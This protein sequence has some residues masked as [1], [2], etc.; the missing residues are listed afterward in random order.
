MS[1]LPDFSRLCL[2]VPT[3]VKSA[4]PEVMQRERVRPQIAKRRHF[5]PLPES[6]TKL[7]EL[8]GEVVSTFDREKEG[9]NLFSLKQL[10]PVMEELG[11][12]L[13]EYGEILDKLVRAL[14][15][16][17]GGGTGLRQFEKRTRRNQALFLLRMLFRH[18]ILCPPNVCDPGEGEAFRERLRAELHKQVSVWAAWTGDPQSEYEFQYRQITQGQPPLP[19]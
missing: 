6:P 8:K 5:R 19:P 10:L 7:V 16:A 15:M 9:P 3:A 13:S 4:K 11:M 14:L 12:A 2:G 18:S 17:E 1:D